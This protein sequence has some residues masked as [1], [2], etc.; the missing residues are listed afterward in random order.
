MI[1][2]PGGDT[3]RVRREWR[4]RRARPRTDVENLAGRFE[5]RALAFKRDPER[6][7]HLTL[8]P[9]CEHLPGQHP[10]RLTDLRSDV[11]GNR[12]GRQVPAPPVEQDQGRLGCHRRPR[13]PYPR[14]PPAPALGLTP[15]G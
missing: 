1:D 7:T 2:I 13:L 10:R 3:C 11:V 14:P 8:G 15:E 12:P 4:A 9:P 6:L 5:C